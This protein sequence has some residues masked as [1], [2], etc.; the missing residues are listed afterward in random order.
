MLKKASIVAT[1]KGRKANDV[2]EIRYK[3]PLEKRNMVE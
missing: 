2:I 3:I 1:E